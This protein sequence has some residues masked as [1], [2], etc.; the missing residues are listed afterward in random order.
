MKHFA[1]LS[2]AGPASKSGLVQWVYVQKEK[3]SILTSLLIL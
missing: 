3:V 2:E 1:E